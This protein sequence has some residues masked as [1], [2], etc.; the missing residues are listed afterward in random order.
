[1]ILKTIDLV[2]ALEPCQCSYRKGRY[3]Q[4][5]TSI[6]GGSAFGD[7]GGASLSDAELNPYAGTTVVIF[8]YLAAREA[9]PWDI[10]ALLRGRWNVKVCWT[11][12]GP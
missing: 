11:G 1:L 4:R 12:C 8:R 9:S 10:P 5:A 3:E 7:W 6:G 2:V